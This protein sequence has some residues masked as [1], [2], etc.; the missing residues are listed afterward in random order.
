MLSHGWRWRPFTACFLGLLLLLTGTAA[1]FAFAL[2]GYRWPDGTQIVIHLQ[3]THGSGALQDGSASWNASAADALNLWNQY[4]DNVQFAE[5]PP[6]GSS[7]S[8][9]A[10]EVLFSGTVYGESWPAN[11]LAVTLRMSSQGNVFTETDVLF[12]ENLKWDSYRGPL[13][14]SGLTGTYD[15]HRVALH[16]FGHVLGLDHPDQHGQS[17][18]AQMNSI[19]SD[20]DHLAEDDIAG[21]ASLYAARITS[22][23]PPNATAGDPYYY[24]I[25]ANNRPTSF[26]ASGLPPGLQVDGATGW[27]TGTPTA[28]GTFNVVLTAHGATRDASAPVPIVVI[29][30]SIQTSIL[31]NA[32]IGTNYSYSVIASRYPATFEAA[33]LPPGLSLNPETGRI[34]GTPSQ[35]GTFNVTFTAHT[36]Y[37]D[38]VATLPLVVLAPRILSFTSIGPIEVAGVLNYQIVASGGATSFSATGLPDGFQIDPVTGVI[39]GTP[40]LSGLYQVTVFAYTPYGTATATLIIGVKPARTGD[41]PIARLW[42]GLSS[43][44]SL[45][46][47]PQR[48]RVYVGTLQ[49]LLVIDVPSLS[50]IKRVALPYTPWDMSVSRDATKLFVAT[51]GNALGIVDLDKLEVLPSLSMAE[52]AE[53]VREGFDRHLFISGL[54]GSAFQ[55][56]PATGG[57]VAKFNPDRSHCALEPSP[58]GK[59]LYVTNLVDFGPTLA[60]YDVSGPSPVLIQSVP[61]N[62]YGSGASLSVSHGGQAVAYSAQQTTRLQ[63]APDLNATLATLSVGVSGAA[64]RV[65]FSGDDSLVFQPGGLGASFLDPG[66][67]GVFSTQNGQRLRTIAFAPGVFPTRI[68]VDRDSTYVFVYTLDPSL[69]FPELKVYPVN[70]GTRNVVPAPRSLLNVSTRL[71]AQAGDNALIGGFIIKGADPKQIALRAMGPSLPV[72]GK[73]VDPILQLYDSSGALIAQNDSWNAHRYDVVSAG[74]PPGDEHEAV[75]IATLQP[76]AYTAVVRGANDSSG[77]ALVEAYDLTSDS[78]SKVANISTRGKVEAGDNVM[79]GGFIVGGGQPTTT[80][81]RAIGPSLQNFAVSEAL[82]DPTLELHDGN[83]ALLA[84]NDDWRLSQQQQLIET[85]L[86]P[87]DNRES[88]LVLALQPGPYTAIVRGK[89][90]QTGVGLVEIYNLDAN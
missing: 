47:D 71:K 61:M 50:V 34:S 68:A 29:G 54:N 90:G 55:I 43:V 31:A 12:N 38:A 88:A 23:H 51:K 66:A 25:T 83:G 80:V 26:S 49:E 89:D 32:D 85:G 36:A 59:T 15:F 69:P 8:D 5:A 67:I 17:V 28:G 27:I 45:V 79:I 11:A 2:N 72:P 58:D 65:A 56:D 86:A 62:G 9:G 22:L 18:V 63:S 7:G 1:A 76:G 24:Q 52:P 37:G 64:G 16:E 82:M 19:I 30:P 35:I 39:S 57:V 78:N 84:Q 3:L 42:V 40:S 48:P 74:L 6:S 20:L 33:G 10:N 13:Q 21:A 46:A 77:V 81:V 41:T 60:R 14:G 4:A 44:Y 75:I 53:Q 87:N 73:L 70:P